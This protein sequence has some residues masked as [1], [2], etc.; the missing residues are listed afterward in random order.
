MLAVRYLVVCR[1]DSSRLT[2][3][4]AFNVLFNTSEDLCI[5]S[6]AASKRVVVMVFRDKAGGCWRGEC[7]LRVKRSHVVTA[8][9]NGYQ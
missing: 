2:G 5:V 9:I 6:T 7:L 8:S 1:K 3:P 4:L